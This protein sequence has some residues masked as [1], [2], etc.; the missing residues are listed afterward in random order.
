MTYKA[1]PQDKPHEPGV[2]KFKI[3]INHSLDI[4]TTHLV[5]LNHRKSIEE[6]F[7][8]NTSIFHFLPQ[9]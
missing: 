7:L 8:S 2:M 4:I 1:T 6:D 5:C 9:N 3:L